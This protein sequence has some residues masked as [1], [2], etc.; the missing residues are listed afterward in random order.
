MGL[1]PGE[2]YIRNNIFVS[3]WKS[4]HPKGALMWGFT[5]FETSLYLLTGQNY[6][7]EMNT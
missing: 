6:R 2:A 3:K 1:H 5:V 4:L 7:H